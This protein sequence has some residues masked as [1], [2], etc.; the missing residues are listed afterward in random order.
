[1]PKYRYYMY[2]YVYGVRIS[3]NSCFWRFLHKT[4]S[5]FGMRFGITK[6][7]SVLGQT[8]TVHT[9]HATLMFEDA[10][11]IKT[12]QLSRVRVKKVPPP[13][14][15]LMTPFLDPALES[16]C[17]DHYSRHIHSSEQKLNDFDSTSIFSE[18]HLNRWGCA[19]DHLWLHMAVLLLQ[20]K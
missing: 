18:V 11:R 8:L 16:C 4:F 9:V 7:A 5:A 6:P 2:L 13:L 19:D 17:I 3:N 1:M 20:D 14:I 15:I 10:H 12:L